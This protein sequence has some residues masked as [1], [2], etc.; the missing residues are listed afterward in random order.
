DI[1]TVAFRNNGNAYGIALGRWAYY[2]DQ[3]I[4]TRATATYPRLSTL[5][6]PN[7]YR[8]S[9]FWIT[10]GSFLRIRHIELGYRFSPAIL[11]R[12][13]IERLRIFANGIN[14]LTWSNLL[15][16]YDMD[17]ETMSGYAAAKSVNF[18]FTVGF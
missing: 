8:N 15:K 17:P 7:N 9:S 6:N 5:D 11:Q 13:G 10:D 16:N 14:L 1:Q 3:G 12:V 4:D 2:P 18:G